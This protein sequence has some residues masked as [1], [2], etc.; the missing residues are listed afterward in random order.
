MNAYK[1]T[2]P[3]PGESF[4]LLSLLSECQNC[5]A[6]PGVTIEL[7]EPGNVLYHE[8]KRGEFNDGQL[9][10]KKWADT[11]GVAIVTGMRMHEFVKAA[12][13]HL[14]GLAVKDFSE[15]GMIDRI[16]A[17]TILE[18]MYEDATSRPELASAGAGG[19]GAGA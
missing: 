10:F 9:K 7:I 17:E 1:Y 12:A 19:K 14:I 4:Y 16:S 15:G 18:E 3:G 6:P 5:D 8:Y 2:F 13:P 11:K